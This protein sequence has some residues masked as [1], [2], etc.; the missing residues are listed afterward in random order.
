MH[1]TLYSVCPRCCGLIS[2]QLVVQLFIY[3]YHSV[4]HFSLVLILCSC[5][6]LRSIEFF[7]TVIWNGRVYI[8]VRLMKYCE[9]IMLSRRKLVRS[10]NDLWYNHRKSQQCVF[11]QFRPKI[12]IMTVLLAQYLKKN[13]LFLLNVR[14]FLS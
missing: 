2:I 11:V 14:T 9:F 3:T 1:P 4:W 8:H 10:M 12:W 6:F 5:G 7:D 13:F